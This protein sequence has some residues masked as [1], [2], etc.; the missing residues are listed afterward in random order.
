MITVTL[1]QTIQATTALLAACLSGTALLYSMVAYTRNLKVS[2]YNELD[3]AYQTLLNIAFQN[4]F[5][6]KPEI[7]TTN[8]QK[9]KYDIYAFMVWNFL[10]A[11]YVKCTK[12]EH[13]RE[14][15]VPII[16]VEGKLHFAWFKREDNK[17][18]FKDIFYK[19]VESL[20]LPIKPAPTAA[21]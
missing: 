6:V 16:E 18:K 15:W 4:P 2:H 7:I 9:E 1:L 20:I 8:E 12:D 11:I 21:I 19:Y 3:K 14:T 13:L 10:E 5:L 17:P